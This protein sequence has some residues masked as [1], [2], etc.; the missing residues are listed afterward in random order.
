MVEFDGLTF[1]T[2]KV[3]ATL[4]NGKKHTY[5]V[6]KPEA[7]HPLTREIIGLR[8]RDGVPTDQSLFAALTE[9]LDDVEV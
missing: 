4:P 3:E 8:F 1:E 2:V 9:V 5:N 7:G 6:E